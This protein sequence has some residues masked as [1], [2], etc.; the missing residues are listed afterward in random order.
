MDLTVHQFEAVGELEACSRVQAFP[1]KLAL[2]AEN[3]RRT[4][5]IWQW[6]HQQPRKLT[7]GRLYDVQSWC[8]LQ[9]LT[10]SVTEPATLV[11]VEQD[12]TI[13]FVTV[14][15]PLT[16]LPN[17]RSPTPGHP[18]S[19]VTP[20][21]ELFGDDVV[22]LMRPV[23]INTT[24]PMIMRQSELPLQR[25]RQ[26]LENHGFPD[27]N[28]S[29]I[30]LLSSKAETCLVLVN[31]R[32][33]F[34]LEIKVDKPSPI[35]SPIPVS[36]VKPSEFSRTF[37]A[38]LDMTAH[39]HL[40]ITAL[41][42]SDDW[43]QMVLGT[44]HHLICINLGTYFK[45]NPEHVR[46]GADQ[47]SQT[48][49]LAGLR[50]QL[51]QSFASHTIDNA[52]HSTSGNSAIDSSDGVPTAWLRVSLSAPL[53]R[54][55][56]TRHPTRLKRTR[57]SESSP[58][59][60]RT[61]S[62]RSELPAESCVLTIHVAQL[63]FMAVLG[64]LEPLA[65]NAPACVGVLVGGLAA[66]QA[67]TLIPTST[68]C[69]CISL[70]PLL[71]LRRGGINTLARASSHRELLDQLYILDETRVA[72][73]LS[74]IN[75][76]D[77][78]TL[79]LHELETALRFQQPDVVSA[80]LNRAPHEQLDAAMEAIERNMTYLYTQ[81]SYNWGFRE[82]LLQVVRRFLM[83][84][85]KDGQN[86]EPSP[87]NVQH[88]QA[89]TRH[90][91]ALLQFEERKVL[92]PDVKP[93]K[94]SGMER[95]TRDVLR[96]LAAIPPSMRS[97]FER[98]KGQLILSRAWHQCSCQPAADIVLQAVND[99]LV[100]Q[101]YLYMVFV[102]DLQRVTLQEPLGEHEPMDAGLEELRKDLAVP[103]LNSAH[104][105]TLPV[106]QDDMTAAA[107]ALAYHAIISDDFDTC[108]AVCQAALLDAHD[109]YRAVFMHTCYPQ[110]A[111]RC[112]E[113]LKSAGACTPAE[114]RLSTLAERFWQRYGT[115]DI[116]VAA[117]K[118]KLKLSRPALPGTIA[119]A[120]SELVPRDKQTAGT[121]PPVQSLLDIDADGN[122]LPRLLQLR[123]QRWANATPTTAAPAKNRAV[124]GKGYA[125]WTVAQLCAMSTATRLLLLV[126]EN[127]LLDASLRDV[128]RW[129]AE[130]G[131]DTIRDVVLE[132]VNMACQ[133]Q[134]T[135]WLAWLE[136][137]L[138]TLV[139]DLSQPERLAFAQQLNLRPANVLL[140][141]ELEKIMYRIGLVQPATTVV[142][143]VDLGIRWQLRRLAR[144]S[145]LLDRAGTDTHPVSSLAALGSKH[146]NTRNLTDEQHTFLHQLCRDN[147]LWSLYQ[148]LSPV[149]ARTAL[150]TVYPELQDRGDL[151][152]LEQ[153]EFEVGRQKEPSSWLLNLRR[154]LKHEPV[155][156]ENPNHVFERFKIEVDQAVPRMDEQERWQLLRSATKLDVERL[157][158]WQVET[159][160][161]DT[162]GSR[163]PST[164]GEA[165]LAHYA[166]LPSC[167]GPL[168]KAF[169]AQD[170]I[171]A[172][173][174]LEHGRPLQA[175]RLCRDANLTLSQW[176][177]D[178]AHLERIFEIAI[179]ARQ[180][181]SPSRHVSSGCIFFLLM[182]NEGPACNV[183]KLA[184][185]VVDLLDRNSSM[186]TQPKFVHTHV[187]VQ[188]AK[189]ARHA[190]LQEADQGANQE[191]G[192]DLEHAAELV[193]TLQHALRSLE[194]R[195]GLPEVTVRDAW[196]VTVKIAKLLQ[197][198]TPT[199]YLDRCLM[200]NDWVNMLTFADELDLGLTEMFQ[201]V[202]GNNAENAPT[203]LVRHLQLM[204]HRLDPER[205]VARVA[206]INKRCITKGHDMDLAE[207]LANFPPGEDLG[208]NL[209]HEAVRL[210]STT[211]AIMAHGVGNNRNLSVHCMLVWLAVT[212]H[213]PVDASNDW[214]ARD[215]KEDLKELILQAAS[216][217]HLQVVQS[218][219]M[220]FDPTSPFLHFLVAMV[221]A[222][223]GRASGCR[224]NLEGYR[225]VLTQTTPDLAAQLKITLGP[226]KWLD[227]LAGDLM[228]CILFRSSLWEFYRELLLETLAK[229]N[230]SD[231][232][233]REHKASQLLAQHGLSSA[234][235]AKP[236]QAVAEF[237]QRHQYDTAREFA[238]LF[239]F[240][241]DHIML[242]EARYKLQE[243][244]RTCF[245]NS[246]TSQNVLLEICHK[247]F[248]AEN[249]SPCLLAGFYLDIASND[250]YN[251]TASIR[252]SLLER[253]ADLYQQ[254]GDPDALE[255][256]KQATALMWRSL[257]ALLH[258]DPSA[259]PLPPSMA[260]GRENFARGWGTAEAISQ[261]PG[262]LDTSLLAW[263]F[264]FAAHPTIDLLL[265]ALFDR[266]DLRTV[267]DVAQVLDRR[268][269]DLAIAHVS[270]LLAQETL[271]PSQA[272]SSLQPMLQDEKTPGS[273][274]DT[275]RQLVESCSVGR[276]FVERLHVNYQ[277]A[278]QL[279]MTLKALL[280][281]EALRAV[282]FLLQQ[283]PDALGLG[284]RFCQVNK[285]E[286]MAVT[287]VVATVYI[288]AIAKNDE[289]WLDLDTSTL[290][291]MGSFVDAPADV[292]HALLRLNASKENGLETSVSQVI[293]MSAA[294]ACFKLGCD[295]RGLQR[296]H[297][298]VQNNLVP[299][300][301]A[302]GDYR[303][304]MKLVM[305]LKTYRRLEYV[306]DHLYKHHQL[307][308]M[309]GS[310]TRDL[311]A[312]E[313]AEYK[314]ALVDFF[315]RRYPEDTD[316]FEMLALRFSLDYEIG[317]S[318]LKNARR[319]A[320]K[321]NLKFDD[322]ELSIQML[323]EAAVKFDKAACP[324]LVRECLLLA[325]IV[326][327][328]AQLQP[329][330]LDLSRSELEQFLVSHG[331]YPE[332]SIV[333]QYYG[334]DN[335]TVWLRPV[336]H[337]V[338]ELGNVDY[339][340]DCAQGNMFEASF[341]RSV[342]DLYLKR[343]NETSDPGP[344][345]VWAERVVA[346]LS[347]CP[348][349]VAIYDKCCKIEQE[350]FRRFAFQLL[351]DSIYLKDRTA[352]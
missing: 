28:V 53:Q 215:V 102:C 1:H 186:P 303:N 21:V 228:D 135:D 128:E 214:Y 43:S 209:L 66:S 78:H 239:D 204:L 220:V 119:R 347:D 243:M 336:F 326:G 155:V 249:V 317:Q 280:S 293:L 262:E 109:F 92:E 284:K 141:Y 143:D 42:A 115:Q 212:V 295:M 269:P 93:V 106:M 29:S 98:W 196:S 145:V 82:Q 312:T 57:P 253:A 157:L 130:L 5:S 263:D 167:T 103:M 48:V 132:L 40:V 2:A 113:R 131:G 271:T 291:A 8:I 161:R 33:V 73:L 343:L 241:K 180:N 156:M 19:P 153:V 225:A 288:K 306:F 258:Q 14:A 49:R 58:S 144:A 77:Q 170:S 18:E 277:V 245:A 83:Q 72:N 248:L 88:L 223:E 172:F 4:V 316:A 126:E 344:D 59:D 230:Y 62:V 46:M 55:A 149:S 318:R 107:Q 298:H 301:E 198:P 289:R 136:R 325:R 146:S 305:G 108:V 36:R 285:L 205:R 332:A 95:A 38:N 299:R 158:A 168:S 308:V 50:Q 200:N 261:L 84:Q 217:G 7:A 302:E 321:P 121:L 246:E 164:T 104:D 111:M 300:L 56:A 47:G 342:V 266:G 276:A 221:E 286:T 9:G 63:E 139:Q 17:E 150:S 272:L 229:I 174:Y 12:L 159:S 124:A 86:Q 123:R 23:E 74:S 202:E 311:S 292:G 54:V 219:F 163:V 287:D 117:K 31:Q 213:L 207:V 290:A 80:T 296:V 185:D 39:A 267:T 279:N 255:K 116:E 268:H 51:R 110:V 309:L 199:G 154:Y 11:A 118:R 351:R 179:T 91:H 27:V 166:R 197:Q 187:T 112:F 190:R 122:W 125:Q 206:P 345:G 85:I 75:D 44:A 152:L 26:L 87:K 232:Y 304:M 319:I 231:R 140:A 315:Q 105:V 227:Q 178:N 236:E 183:L 307:E 173:Y 129:A 282:R 226:L 25:T 96:Q 352:L 52:G 171:D 283:G 195:A 20:Q 13:N 188:F 24:V 313:Q 265:A 3:A 67:S 233:V 240:R 238:L 348:D 338:V 192:L 310:S 32:Y 137:L 235:I 216:Q 191:I 335:P 81:V 37:F 69:I 327:L 323:R 328:Q 211:L 76:W 324:Q 281:T 250:E 182:C 160:H 203:N 45:R 218:A 6:Q 322:L 349:A 101:A 142:Q 100:Q 273:T 278:K 127:E 99:N 330:V 340:T 208:S 147:R 331:A 68:P 247:N 65:N 264:D 61:L 165:D 210:Q 30:S 120:L 314:T 294:Y 189:A 337:Q 90:L 320:Q 334:A 237:L 252:V 79:L 162:S 177:S 257:I 333:A 176:I 259:I 35:K 201:V 114:E 10:S 16:K 341:Y 94:L 193:A 181:S 339:W 346:I 64:S 256:A 97:H 297:F 70:Q 71:L 133:L 60:D 224:K 34:A 274:A 350:A 194:R 138:V 184:L 329:N 148:R 234:L 169:G 275:L 254:H 89:V 15:P 270:S 22:S 242:E 244:H 151:G 260:R 222:C 175:Y 134:R 41:A 251:F